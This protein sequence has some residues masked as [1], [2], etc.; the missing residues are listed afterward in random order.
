MTAYTDLKL[1]TDGLTAVKANTTTLWICSSQPTTYTQASSTY[2]LGV[3]T[4]G[5]GNVLGAPTIDAGTGAN[6]GVN[7][8]ASGGAINSG[9][10]AA[11]WGIGYVSG[12]VL[13]AGY[14]LGSSQA[15]TAGNTFTT[16][17]AT[18]NLRGAT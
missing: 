2:N 4:P 3:A 6:I 5:A 10:T 14:S 12:S 17:T 15:V 11:F 13:Y 1:F 9:G 7:A 8:V 16:G 18:I